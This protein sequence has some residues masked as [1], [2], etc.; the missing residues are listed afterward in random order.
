[1]KWL[2]MIKVNSLIPKF[3]FTVILLLFYACNNNDSELWNNAKKDYS[4]K[5]YENCVIKLQQII[6]SESDLE[7]I[8]QSKYLLSEIYLNEYD[9]YFIALDYLNMI[10]DEHT[11]HELAKKSLFTAAYIYGNYLDAYTDSYNYYNKFLSL[12]PQDD[13]IESVKYEL[14][15]LTPYLNKTKSLINN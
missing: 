3:L 4:N 13:L 15:N 9:Q 14:N 6:D 1:M 5:D 7:T 8:I 12:Y 10:I 2:M 11:Q